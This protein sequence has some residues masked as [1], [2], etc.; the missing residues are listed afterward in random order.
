MN[1]YRHIFP[2]AFALILI[3]FV[4]NVCVAGSAPSV[5]DAKNAVRGEFERQGKTVKSVDITNIGK[6]QSA[7]TTTKGA[8]TY[9]MVNAT[10]DE[11]GGI[12]KV[13]GPVFMLPA[14]VSY[15]RS[16]DNT[17]YFQFTTMS[18]VKR[19]DQG[20]VQ[21]IRANETAKRKGEL[22]KNAQDLYFAEHQ[23]FTCDINELMNRE[24]WL[25]DHGN[26][27]FTFERCNAQG[28]S[29]TSRHVKGNKDYKYSSSF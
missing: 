11:R 9:W 12:R 22:A 15:D 21:M 6:A 17:W 13:A 2:C 3:A 16:E 5:E 28:Y 20:D 25:T 8:I 10:V 27:T 7:N 26:V 23:K 19:I 29:F 1:P 4:A 14:G 18:M 24:K